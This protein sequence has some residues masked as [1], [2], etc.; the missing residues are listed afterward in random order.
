VGRLRDALGIRLIDVGAAMVVAVVV[1]LNVAT[2]GGAG[3]ARLNALA[4]VFGG[5]LGARD[6]AQLVVIAY[7]TGLATPA[8]P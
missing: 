7:A 8:A 2:G 1:E 5:I 6:S 4:Y 3:S